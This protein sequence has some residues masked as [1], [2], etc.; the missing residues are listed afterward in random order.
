MQPCDNSVRTSAIERKPKLQV[1]SLKGMEYSSGR[2]VTSTPRLVDRQGGPWYYFLVAENPRYVNRDAKEVTDMLL[3]GKPGRGPSRGFLLALV[4]I[5]VV[6]AGFGAHLFLLLV[7]STPGPLFV[8][9]KSDDSLWEEEPSA[10]RMKE[11]T[12]YIERVR[13][14]V[15]RFQIDKQRFPKTAKEFTAYMG[16]HANDRLGPMEIRAIIPASYGTPE[17]IVL[18]HH[19]ISDFILKYEVFSDGRVLLLTKNSALVQ[20]LFPS[21]PDLSARRLKTS[22]P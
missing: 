13:H 17:K 9:V 15:I 7:S 11:L 20:E 6:G 2:S 1:A 4:A 3:L 14:S 19:A 22:A 8:A 16:P 10:E 21:E 12:D 5:G 18:V